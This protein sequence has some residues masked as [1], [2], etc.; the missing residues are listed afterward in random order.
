LKAHALGTFLPVS[1][2]FWA[3]FRG[4]G[5]GANPD[6]AVAQPPKIA[7]GRAW[8]LSVEFLLNH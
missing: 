3:G 2:E 1:G 4:I 6:F 7:A 8:R 5:N